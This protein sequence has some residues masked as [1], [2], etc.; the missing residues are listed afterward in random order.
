MD[1]VRCRL[2]VS[3][4]Q[5]N[6]SGTAQRHVTFGDHMSKRMH[7][8]ESNT[9]SVELNR[10]TTPSLRPIGAVKIYVFQYSPA[11]YTVISA[12]HNGL[13]AHLLPKLDW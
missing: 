9:L 5:V 8:G 1:P 4:T 11:G 7:F 13:S 10:P 2:D 12:G 6:W 3:L